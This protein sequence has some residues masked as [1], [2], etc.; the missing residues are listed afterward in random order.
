MDDAALVDLNEL[1]GAREDDLFDVVVLFDHI[2][3]LRRRLEEPSKVLFR[4]PRMDP[5]RAQLGARQ[6]ET[7]LAAEC[8]WFR[9]VYGIVALRGGSEHLW[10]KVTY[11]RG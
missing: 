10:T 5:R 2:S 6:E 8:A 4:V 11:R 7:Q 3:L 9:R 1:S